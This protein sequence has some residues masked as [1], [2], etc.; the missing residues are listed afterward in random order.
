MSTLLIVG[1][2]LL[3]IALLAAFLGH[4]NIA[5]LSADLGK[6]VLFVGLAIFVIILVVDLLR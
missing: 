6:T 3:V 1:I 4:N 5:G 2:I